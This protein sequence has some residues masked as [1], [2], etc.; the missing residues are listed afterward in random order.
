MTSDEHRHLHTVADE[1]EANA[2]LAELERAGISG[3]VARTP[4]GS[5][6]GAV[7]VESTDLPRAKRILRAWL[8]DGAERGRA[9]ASRASV[10]GWITLAVLVGS[11]GL[12]VWLGLR[13]RGA[14]VVVEGDSVVS[15][16]AEGRRR[17]VFEYR[18]GSEQPFRTTT[19]DV[20]GREIGIAYDDDEDGTAERYVVPLG[21]ALA[22]TG[23]KNK[24]GSASSRRAGATGITALA[25]RT[26]TRT[27]STRSER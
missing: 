4:G 1:H 18:H 17:A 8:R 21:R 6:F 5:G 7:M 16:D 23:T 2:L 19:Y 11:L 12:N 20:E 24:T 14:V 26:G 9:S 13:L 15:R 25:W 3:E 27:V 10:I 22:S